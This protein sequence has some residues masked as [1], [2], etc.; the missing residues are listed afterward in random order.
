MSKMAVNLLQ[1][2]S[3]D[4]LEQVLSRLHHP[5]SRGD[6]LWSDVDLQPVVLLMDLSILSR[7]PSVL[8]GL[9]ELSKSPSIIASGKF[10]EFVVAA[11]GMFSWLCAVSMAIGGP[12]CA[13]VTSSSSSCNQ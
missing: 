3:M 6:A 1:P 4:K 7:L 9:R 13:L 2:G 10:K 8:D 5:L 12:C 11:A